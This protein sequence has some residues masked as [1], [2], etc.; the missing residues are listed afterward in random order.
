[1]SSEIEAYY[2]SYDENGR[3]QRDNAHRVEF[4][5]T[6]HY[7]QKLFKPGSAVLDACAGTGACAFYLAEKGHTVT[8]CDLVAHNVEMMRDNPGAQK[9]KEISVRNVLDLSCFPTGQFD[10]VL[11]MGALYHLSN[12][13]D[14]KKAILECRRVLKSDGFLALAYLN[15]FACIPA[16]VDAGLRNIDEALAIL[17]DTVDMLFTSTT[18]AKMLELAESCGLEPIH[19]IGTDGL[20]YIIGDKINLAG[21]ENFG[22]WME[23]HLATCEEPSTLGAS[24]HGLDICQKR[25]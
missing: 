22:K 6:G 18:P 4:L 10:V 17:Y 15:K 2:E 21:D 1:M 20:A 9:L 19:R 25:S 3:L 7:F 8:A 12:E 13:R 5:T 16:N 11:C 14:R 23:Y 24:L